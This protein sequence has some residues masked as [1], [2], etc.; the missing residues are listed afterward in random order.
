MYFFVIKRPETYE[1][2]I[3]KQT[4]ELQGCSQKNWH[5]CFTIFTKPNVARM[6][7]W[8]LNNSAFHGNSF[9]RRL[10][11]IIPT[12]QPRQDIFDMACFF[13]RNSDLLAAWVSWLFFCTCW[14]IRL[15]QQLPL[16][17]S[18]ALGFCKLLLS[19]D[20]PFRWPHNKKFGGLMSG[21]LAGQR[22]SVLRELTCIPKCFWMSWI[23]ADAVCGVAISCRS[24][25][26]HVN[27]YAHTAWSRGATWWCNV[28]FQ[29]SPSVC[30]WHGPRTK[31]VQSCRVPTKQVRTHCAACL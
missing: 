4:N 22:C 2:A 29:R 24:Q 27:L 3:L 28:T 18:T 20:N 16:T 31:M 14:R 6:N 26:M 12:S 10:N 11:Y 8:I 1:W 13:L 19:C 23:V 21:K 9:N 5:I 25:A 30:G 7:L 15:V 17:S